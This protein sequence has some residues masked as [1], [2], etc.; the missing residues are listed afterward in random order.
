MVYAMNSPMFRCIS[1]LIIV[2]CFTNP[3]AKANLCLDIYQDKARS[4]GRTFTTEKPNDSW[5]ITQKI[6][7]SGELIV[8][9]HFNTHTLWAGQ[10]ESVGSSPMLRVDRGMS[11]SRQWQVSNLKPLSTRTDQVSSE[12]LLQQVYEGSSRLGDFLKEHYPRRKW[13]EEFT[14]DK[15]A[16]PESLNQLFA[17]TYRAEVFSPSGRLIGSGVVIYSPFI[18]VKN[19]ATGQRRTL[20]WGAGRQLLENL[21]SGNL[22]RSET[23][24][25]ELPVETFFGIEVL[26]NK[27]LGTVTVIN[28]KGESF[29]LEVGLLAE[30]GSFA[31]NNK[32]PFR[33][34]V[35]Q[36]LYYEFLIASYHTPFRLHE[37]APLVNL[38]ALSQSPQFQGQAVFFTYG[39]GIGQRLYGSK[40]FEFQKL[41]E[42]SRESYDVEW[43]PLVQGTQFLQNFAQK[44]DFQDV[45]KRAFDDL[46]TNGVPIDA[47]Q[48][49]TPVMRSMSED[50][51]DLYRAG[52]YQQDFLNFS[53][54]EL[55]PIFTQ[56]TESVRQD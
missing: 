32:S 46:I 41:E 14:N 35:L 20:P 25:Y 28:S 19:L 33:E 39:D 11:P 52:Q 15:A 9:S 23:G 53:Q 30:I 6:R 50:M 3:L 47:P 10:S 27:G 42:V 2:L 21:E 5:L 16:H 1:S 22:A 44:K 51:V 37:R 40:P 7:S 24:R 18:I 17:Q 38:A 56:F 13:N 54:S 34:Q 36:E 8:E 12:S 55:L 43:K 29:T 49:R 31:I 4:L 26:R 48:L 45:A